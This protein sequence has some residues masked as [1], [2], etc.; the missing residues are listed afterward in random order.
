MEGSNV[1]NIASLEAFGERV[2]APPAAVALP[3]ERSPVAPGSDSPQIHRV[4]EMSPFATLAGPGRDAFLEL[5]RLEQLPRRHRIAEQGE[6]AKSFVMIGSGRVRLDR[7]TGGHAFP[8]GH[9]GPGEMVGET[10][11]AAG[12]AQENATVLDDV[13]ALVLPAPA[14]RRL[15]NVEPTVQA[16]MA[17]ALVAQQRTAESRLESLLLRG[18]EAR[19]CDFLLVSLQRWGHPHPLGEMIAAPFTHAEIALLIGSTRETVTLLLGKLKRASL[20]EFDKRR[21]V[22]RDRAGLSERAATL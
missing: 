11:I 19:L 4:F 7:T 22:I 9:R 6:P 21:L 10:A 18:V 5:A 15:L 8:V 16:A 14:F 3:G 20:L 12:I 17:A 2:E 13:E 1:R